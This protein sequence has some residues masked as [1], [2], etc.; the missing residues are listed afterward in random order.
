MGD[1]TIT[2]RRKNVF[3]DIAPEQVEKFKAKGYD[4]VDKFGNVLEK[5]TPNDPNALKHAYDEQVAE[6]ANLK[7]IIRK[8]E[9]ELKAKSEIPA[10]VETKAEV[11]VIPE[12]PEVSAEEIVPEVKTKT[13]GKRSKKNV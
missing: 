9:A 5:S 4:V 10:K 7:A 1:K 2:V 3:L 11:P 6:I 12:E 8:L 13:S